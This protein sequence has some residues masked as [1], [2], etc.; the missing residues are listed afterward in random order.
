VALTSFR[1]AVGGVVVVV[2]DG[3]VVVVVDDG[4]GGDA[5]D[6]TGVVTGAD[7]GVGVCDAEAG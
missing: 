1:F 3:G 5:D 2:V 4:G 6:V 7:V